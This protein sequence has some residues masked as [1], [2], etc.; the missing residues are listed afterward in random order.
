MVNRSS[1][2]TLE[3]LNSYFPYL[4]NQVLNEVNKN[5]KNIPD[6]EVD[7]LVQ[8]LIRSKLSDK[9][10]NL[11]TFKQELTEL[12]II[13]PKEEKKEDILNEKKHTS[14]KRK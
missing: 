8:H 7:N 11:K 9:M 6:E 14:I 2:I 4:Q 10:K 1:Q 13:K 5:F 12:G 3:Y